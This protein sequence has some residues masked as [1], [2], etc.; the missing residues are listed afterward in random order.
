M[1]TTANNPSWFEWSNT[2]RTEPWKACALALNIDPNEVIRTTDGM[3]TL[4]S[5]VITYGGFPS[6]EVAK[7]FSTL[8]RL[9]N[10]NQ[11]ERHHFSEG[12]FRGVRLDEFAAWCAHVGFAIPPELAALAKAATQAAPM[13]EAA[14]VEQVVPADD[15][16]K[17]L[18]AL[19]DPLPVEAIAKMFMTDV[20]QWKKWAE[21]AKANGLIDA[22]EESAKFNPYKA[23]VW[24]VRK[25]AEGWDVARLY[26]TL[27]NNL[28]ARSRDNVHLLTSNPD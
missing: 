4:G 12:F 21:K 7:Q 16:D 17:T 19:F 9:L 24:F 15:H 18:A 11:F 13:V 26:R 5:G 10:A 28:P 23:G 22:R 1:Q 6:V 2:P 25:G 20:T 3:G 8:L 27:A 14:P